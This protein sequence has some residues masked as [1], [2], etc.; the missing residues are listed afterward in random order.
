MKNFHPTHV[1]PLLCFCLLP[2]AGG[3]QQDRPFNM[4]MRNFD[5]VKQSFHVI[6]KSGTM[7]VPNVLSENWYGNLCSNQKVTTNMVSHIILMR[8]FDKKGNELRCPTSAWSDLGNINEVNVF[9]QNDGCK[10]VI[11]GGDGGVGYK[12]VLWFSGRALIKRR[13]SDG[14]ADDTDGDAFE[15]TTYHLK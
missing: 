2:S 14:V 7:K 15:F 6:L 11:D 1:L 12:A 3:T 10:I 4:N 5:I 8:V 13:V 9:R